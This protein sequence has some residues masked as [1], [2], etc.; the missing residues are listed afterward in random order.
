MTF[1]DEAASAMV[2]LGSIG[3]LKQVW[4]NEGQSID[5][6]DATQAEGRY[7]LRHATQIKNIWV[8]YGE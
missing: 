8:P 4:T 5:W 3:N 1:R 7:F 6:F 2:K